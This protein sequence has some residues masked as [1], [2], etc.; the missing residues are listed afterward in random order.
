MLLISNS[1]RDFGVTFFVAAVVVL[2]IAIVVVVAVMVVLVMAAVV[3]SIVTV[4]VATRYAY[5]MLMSFC[6]FHFFISLFMSFC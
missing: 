6:L 2:V 5:V 3:Q 4:V 1:Y